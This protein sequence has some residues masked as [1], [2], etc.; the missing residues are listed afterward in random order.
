MYF[1]PRTLKYCHLDRVY[2][3]I[4]CV[5]SNTIFCESKTQWGSHK[6]RWKSIYMWLHN[7]SVCDC[8]HFVSTQTSPHLHAHTHRNTCF[9]YLLM[10]GMKVGDRNVLLYHVY[11][12]SLIPSCSAASLSSTSSLFDYIGHLRVLTRYTHATHVV[13][14][15]LHLLLETVFRVQTII[16]HNWVSFC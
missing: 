3:C 1:V 12:S 10:C 4:V 2:V 6:C 16:N 7:A 8:V 13:D 5:T 14:V 15:V 11:I 9:A